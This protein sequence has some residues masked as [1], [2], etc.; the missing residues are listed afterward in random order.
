MTRVDF[1]ILTDANPEVRFRTACRITEKAYLQGL[2]VYLQAGTRGEAQVLDQLLWTF[3]DQAFVPHALYPTAPGDRS[4][5][6]IG[7]ARGDDGREQDHQEPPGGCQ[8]LVNLAPTV[9]RFFGAFE[10]VIEIIDGDRQRR[11]E[12]RQRYR[13][14]RDQGYS[15]QNHQL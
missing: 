5:V 8:V 6:L 1:Y 9:P 13:F 14:Y 4:P 10:R 7:Y 12:G 2:T 15:L 11:E 3:R